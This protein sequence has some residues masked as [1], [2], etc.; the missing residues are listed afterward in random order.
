MTGQELVTAVQYGAPIVVLVIDNGMLGTIRMHQE[1]HYPGRVSATGSRQPG[2]R[3]ARQGVRWL[4]RADRA[5]R[6][7]RR[8]VRASTGLGRTRCSPPTGRSRGDHAEADDHADPRGRSR[9]AD[10]LGRGIAVPR[11]GEDDECMRRAVAAVVVVVLLGA[12]AAGVALSATS[13]HTPAQVVARFKALTHTTLVVD[14]R[15]SYPGHYTALGVPQSISNIGRYGR[16]TI[17]WSPPGDEEDVHDLLA[18][19]HTGELGRLAFPPSTGSTGRPWAAPSTRWRRSGTG[20]TSCSG[21]TAPGRGRR[22]F[23][24]LHRP[25]TAIAATRLARSVPLGG[26]LRPAVGCSPWSPPCSRAAA[27]SFA[28]PA[29]PSRSPISPMLSLRAISSSSA[30]SCP[31]T[32]TAELVGGDDVAA[33]A[34]KVFENMGDVLAAAGCSFADVVKVTVFLTDVNDR[35]LVNPVR[36]QVF[37]DT[38]P[39]STLVEVPALVIPG[40]QD[41][42]RGDRPHAGMTVRE[43]IRV[44]RPAADRCSPSLPLRGRRARRPLRLRGRDPAGRR[45]R[46]PRRR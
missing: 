2:L 37:G 27:S 22:H 25:L 8:R 10:P 21:G 19:P 11:S 31:S 39:A 12:L 24:R 15:S 18:N 1:R 17:W 30:A 35:P 41:R 16:F 13:A 7:L 34:R 23:Q 20:R 14:K 36:Q 46:C 45:D 28:S 26:R 9:T 4:R 33:Q 32:G 29:R 38:R 5:H 42:G 3:R 44:P 43:E 40:R 6:G